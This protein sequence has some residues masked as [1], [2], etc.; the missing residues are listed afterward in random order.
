MIVLLYLILASPTHAVSL[1]ALGPRLGGDAL[2]DATQHFRKALASKDEAA[3]RAAVHEFLSVGTAGAADRAIEACLLCDNGWAEEIA[4]EGLVRATGPFMAQLCKQALE[5]SDH[6]VRLQLHEVLSQKRDNEAYRTVISGLRDPMHEVGISAID[7]LRKKNDIRCVRYVIDALE[8]YEADG[9]GNSVIAWKARHLLQFM[10]G[11]EFIKASQWRR[12]W[13]KHSKKFK[14][15]RHG[16]KIEE[17]EPGGM[18]GVGPRKQYPRF[19]GIEILSQRIVFLLDTSMSMREADPGPGDRP[20]RKRL[21]R[22]QSEARRLMNSLPPDTKFTVIAFSSKVKSLSGSLLQATAANKS[23]AFKF[24]DNFQAEGQ[25]HTDEALEA[26][27][28]IKG[29][30]TI[31]LLSDGAPVRDTKAIDIREI[32]SW[33][34]KENRFRKIQIHTVGF[35]GTRDSIGTFLRDVAADNDG[36]HREL[37]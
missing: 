13:E 36:V 12:F 26:A 33:L 31:F 15:P 1:E 37:P 29:V 20:D 27:F 32:L 35:A 7:A 24:I 14:T 25:T 17:L 2:N 9:W 8:S 16:K 18:T 4:R 5:H 11:E 21:E 10:T 19:F 6:R 3:L 34:R 28:R 22:L 30:R 23:R